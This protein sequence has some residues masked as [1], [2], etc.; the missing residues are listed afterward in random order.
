VAAE[1][2]HAGPCGYDHD[3]APRR[4][5]YARNATGPP[6]PLGT[7]VPT[8]RRLSPRCL[9]C[10]CPG[11]FHAALACGHRTWGCKAVGWGHVDLM[12]RPI[13]S[14]RGEA[15][16]GS[17]ARL[18]REHVRASPKGSCAHGQNVLRYEY[19][20]G[21][22]PVRQSDASTTR[23][24][25]TCQK[26]ERLRPSYGDGRWIGSAPSGVPATMF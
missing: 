26:R 17:M 5:C 2:P 14:V 21:H 23:G 13:P 10:A 22:L 15:F 6:G 1:P 9:L 12:S 11:A 20:R 24:R 25:F 3:C 7:P 8:R 4:P 16:R 19:R 18:N